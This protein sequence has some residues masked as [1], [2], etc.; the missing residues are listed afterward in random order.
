MI[1]TSLL[2]LFFIM[3]AV[4]TRKNSKALMG[5]SIQS[6]LKGQLH[7]QANI[8]WELTLVCILYSPC[9]PEYCLAS[10]PL[11]LHLIANPQL[12]IKLKTMGAIVSHNAL[13]LYIWQA[14]QAR[15]VALPVCAAPSITYE[16]MTTML[17]KWWFVLFIGCY[18][19]SDRGKG[20]GISF[21]SISNPKI[22]PEKKDLAA[23]WLF[24]IGT[25][26]TM[27]N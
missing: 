3:M 5:Y 13:L 26:W 23:R 20:K 2:K 19:R 6:F 7:L 1:F 22:N 24:N 12:A 4:S 25:E 27:K 9:S 17:W 8:C 10:L 14:V 16:T 21:F 15:I 11:K 18:N